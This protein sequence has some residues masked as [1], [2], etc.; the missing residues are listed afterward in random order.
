MEWRER[1][2]T[3]G[4]TLEMTGSLIKM[5]VAEIKRRGV[6]EKCRNGGNGVGRVRDGMAFAILSSEWKCGRGTQGGGVTGRTSVS[7]EHTGNI[8]LISTS[9]KVQGVRRRETRDG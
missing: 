7:S 8:S 2:G 1:G 5:V 3:E 4:G 9:G 6:R